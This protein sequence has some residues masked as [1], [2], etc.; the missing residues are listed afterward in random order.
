MK[1]TLIKQISLFVTETVRLQSEKR[2]DRIRERLQ[3]ITEG[4]NSAP[5]LANSSAAL[6]LES[7]EFPGIPCTM[8]VQEKEDSCWQRD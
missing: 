3:G 8:I 5:S 1:T 6:F 4:R 2:E 7:K